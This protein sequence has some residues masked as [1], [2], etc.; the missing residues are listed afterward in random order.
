MRT[1]VNEPGP[2]PNAI[3]SRSRERP[4]GL[5]QH[6]V[7][8]R[9]QPFRMRVAR[10]FRARNA[11]FAVAARDR[12]PLRRRVEG[13]ELHPG[14]FTGRTACRPPVRTIGRWW[15]HIARPVTSCM[16]RPALA[17][18][19]RR[20]DRIARPG[21]SRRRAR[22][23]QGDVRRRRVARR[24]GDA[25]T[26]KD[27]P[28]YTIARV[29]RILS[30]SASRVVPRCPH[31]GVCGGCTLQHAHPSLQIAA[32]QRALED[33]LARIG[34]VRPDVMLPP[35]EG[36]AWRYRYRARMSVRHVPK[37]G[38]VLVGFHERK[39]SFVADMTECHVVPPKLS[40]L[41]PKL[42]ALVGAL[43]IRDRL[44]QIEV[45]IGERGEHP[46]YALVLRIL[47]PLTA[48]TNAR[49]SR[50]RTRTTWNSGCRP[51]GPRR[52]RRCIRATRRSHMRCRSSRSPCRSGPPNS[53][54]STMPIN[55]VLVRR[56][57]A[58]LA[59]QP[60]ERVADFFCGLGNFTLPIARRGA[61]VVGVEGSA[62]LVRRAEENAPAT[63]WPG[64]PGLRWPISS[65]SPPESLAAFGRLDRALI[66][67]PR[68]GAVELVKALP[69]RDDVAGL[70]RIVYVS[71]APGTLARDA[72]VLVHER[73]YRLAAAGVVNMFPHTAHVESIAVFDKRRGAAR[74]VST[75]SFPLIALARERQQ[76]VQQA[77]EDVVDVEEQPQRGHDVV[78]LAAPD[79]VA[80]VI[81]D[82]GREDQHGDRRDR[83]RQRRDLEEDVRERRDD[84]QDHAR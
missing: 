27:K 67:P 60:G 66:D 8:Q 80:H 26:L 49:S 15:P 54:R 52:W 3:A 41:L 38:G 34:R 40:R 59:P 58:L 57:I 51:A 28:N 44:P 32:K 18:D 19:H 4:A 16:P 76:D 83:H 21:R 68:E 45:A 36:P 77:D 9:Q 65:P 17:A 63:A 24:A 11:A 22:R 35:I 6:G 79:D 74:P 12:Q 53:R 64:M 48:K 82:V 5:R 2:A 61:Q 30:A 73:G 20:L 29:V 1:P 10:E 31:F 69:R 13:K 75:R 50:S 14:D 37:K 81:Q 72:A 84:Q 70:K 25:V 7:D 33:A 46:V 47:A 71:C 42:R 55:R 62:A 39:S 23:R 78:R 56:A 43:S